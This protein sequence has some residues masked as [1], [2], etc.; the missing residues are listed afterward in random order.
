MYKRKLPVEL[1]CGL[2]VFM[3]VLNGKWKINLIWCIFGGISRPGDLH[4]R[5]PRASRRLLD[6]Q[7]K[8]LMDHGIISKIIFD[9]KPARVEYKLTSLGETLMPII[10]ST[11]R[12]GELH[13]KELEPLIRSNVPDL[14]SK[15]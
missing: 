8:Q 15:Q 9:Q 10:E 1:D 3:E 2:H 6:V 7:L 14:L 11:A 5:L 4:R 13:R 12:W